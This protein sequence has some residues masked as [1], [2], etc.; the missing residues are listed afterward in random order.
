M[1][2]QI[3]SIRDSKGEMFYPPFFQKTPGEAERALSQLVQDPKTIVAQYPEDFDLYQLGEFD[4]VTGKIL[5]LSTPQHVLKAVL[6][7]PKKSVSREH[8]ET[9][10]PMPPQV[11]KKAASKKRLVKTN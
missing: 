11:K 3:Y 5:S 1:K 8:I 7:Y 4:D 9:P 10:I 6:A 2:Y